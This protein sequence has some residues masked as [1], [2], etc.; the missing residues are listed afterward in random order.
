[1]FDLNDFMNEN[2]ED[3]NK[4]WPYVPVHLYRVLIIVGFGSIK[5]NALINLMKEQDID[6]P[7]DKNHLNA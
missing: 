5:T 4:K 7:I 1:M 6:N 3:H 2:N